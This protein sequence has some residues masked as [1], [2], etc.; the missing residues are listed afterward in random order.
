MPEVEHNAN[1]YDPPEIAVSLRP[2]VSL[3]LRVKRW[4]IGI[5]GVGLIAFALFATFMVVTRHGIAKG[6]PAI[7]MTLIV[8]CCGVFLMHTAL[9]GSHKDISNFSLMP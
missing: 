4:I 5:I 6:S 1:P 2:T 7:F 8:F 3:W 9:R